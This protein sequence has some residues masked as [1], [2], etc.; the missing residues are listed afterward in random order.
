MHAL[1]PPPGS[2]EVLSFPLCLHPFFSFLVLQEPLPH[3][4]PT[5]HPVLFTSP[6]SQW[7]SFPLNKPEFM[8][9]HQQPQLSQYIGKISSKSSADAKV[10]DYNKPN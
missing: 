5:L 7:L 4:A 2:S 6:K 1:P 8:G 10:Y 3:P 9:T